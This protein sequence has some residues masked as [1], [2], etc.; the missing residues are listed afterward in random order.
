MDFAV[1]GNI[2]EGDRL[3]F[4]MIM[5]EMADS[6]WKDVTVYDYKPFYMCHDSTPVDVNASINGKNIC[7]GSLRDNA[8]IFNKN[9]ELLNINSKL[10]L[11]FGVLSD[12]G[13]TYGIRSTSSTAQNYTLNFHTMLNGD[14]LKVF[15]RKTIKVLPQRDYSW[16][17]FGI[18]Y[19]LGSY[20]QGEGLFDACGVS[21]NASIGIAKEEGTGK[22]SVIKI[23]YELPEGLEFDTVSTVHTLGLFKSRGD[24][25][26][27][28]HNE[29][30]TIFADFSYANNSIKRINN[31][32]VEQIITF[33]KDLP[34]YK[35]YAWEANAAS[36]PNVIVKDKNILKQ[37]HDGVYPLAKAIKAT[38]FVNGKS[39]NTVTMDEATIKNIDSFGLGEGADKPDEVTKK[40]NRNYQSR[41]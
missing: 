30:S 26:V 2:K 28:D 27:K 10:Q 1:V 11:A 24:W 20:G 13:S 5:P 23:R 14:I 22:N 35:G 40:K 29:L 8:M 36:L 32:T 34:D 15:F 39:T 7:I 3:T 37:G 18:G 16:D 21:L 38:I 9:A 6:S 19:T 25:V 41:R 31:S 17:G 33:N 12:S 4:N